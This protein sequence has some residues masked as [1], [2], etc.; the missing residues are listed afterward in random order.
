[1]HARA[2]NIERSEFA[3]RIRGGLRKEDERAS[4]RERKRTTGKKERKTAKNE[5]RTSGEAGGE[6]SGVSRY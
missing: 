3:E 1:L 6:V 5:T 2:M 4:E